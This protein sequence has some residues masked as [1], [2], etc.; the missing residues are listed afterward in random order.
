MMQSKLFM[1]GDSKFRKL[2]TL[3]LFWGKFYATKKSKNAEIV[4]G[5]SKAKSGSIAIKIRQPF[6]WTDPYLHC[7]LKVKV[8]MG[9]NPG[10][11]LEYF[12][13]Y[14]LQKTFKPSVPHRGKF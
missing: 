14:I 4:F 1:A 6:L 12:L 3:M 9:L 13:R 8:I 5:I 7:L 10:Y 11:L 2:Q